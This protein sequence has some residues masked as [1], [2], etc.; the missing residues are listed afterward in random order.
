MENKK[1]VLVGM[2]GGIDSSMSAY[3]LKNEGYEVTG[4]YMKL[5]DIKVGYH[6]KNIKLGKNIAQYLGIDYHVLDLSKEFKDEVYDYFV[7]EYQ[8]GNTPNPC[9][10]CNR[11]IK[12]GAM[13]DFAKTLGISYIATGHYV[14]TDGIFIYEA[15][16]DLKDQSYFLA[17]VKQEV[18][19]SLISPMA[20]YK[21]EFIVDIAKKIPIFND[22]LQ[23]NESQEICFVDT[24]YT[25]ILRQH[26]D[27]DKEGK[28]LD[29]QGN[30]IGNHKGYMHYTVGKR[31]GFVVHGATEPHYIK[32]IDPLNN[33][34][35]V[36][37]KEELSL[38]RVVLDRL[39]LFMDKNEFEC[40]VKLRYRTSKIKCKVSIKEQK[41]YIEL[42][43]DGY[44]VAVGQVAVFYDFNRVLGSGFIIKRY[45][46]KF[47]K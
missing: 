3:F 8:K 30:D 46:K 13:F 41:A 15:D 1:K 2:S 29:T 17:Q 4:V 6:E 35:T 18:L 24:V 10:K 38:N 28:V 44:G 40:S 33:T 21:K 42:Y 25:D 45:S 22:I 20:G 9:I 7:Q 32:E 37:S 16:D 36:S 31:R 23:Q 27:I 5:H 14:R 12:F 11:T 26:Y 43:E 47:S 34:L 39:N 19:K